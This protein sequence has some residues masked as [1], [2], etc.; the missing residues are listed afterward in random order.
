MYACFEIP[1]Y[2]FVM[3]YFFSIFWVGLLVLLG[4]NSMFF[5]N[6]EL[7]IALALCIF[8]SIVVTMLKKLFLKVFFLEVK[9]IYVC[10]SFLFALNIKL[11]SIVWQFV[12]FLILKKR[13][14]VGEFF[15]S[16]TNSYI[17][18]L[19][20]QKTFFI[21]IIDTFIADTLKTF[22]INLLK[23]KRLV[24]NI[25]LLSSISAF[26]Y[27]LNFENKILSFYRHIC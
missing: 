10:F 20:I 17:T 6:E 11:I 21:N 16:L 13:S 26:Y 15:Y 18:Y 24:L 14:F 12:N 2:L 1:M 8:I 4:N 22:F 23:I 3:L 27:R 19:S 25:N 9:F 7:I 5:F